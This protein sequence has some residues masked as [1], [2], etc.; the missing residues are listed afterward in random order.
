MLSNHAWDKSMRRLDGIIERC[1]LTSTRAR[2]T[3]VGVA[4]AEQEK[5]TG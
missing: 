4:V 3:G 1:L 5:V 2:V